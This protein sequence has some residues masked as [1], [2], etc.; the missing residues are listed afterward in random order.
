MKSNIYTF[1]ITSVLC[2]L[3][4]LVIE[5]SSPFSMSDSLF[6]YESSFMEPLFFMLLGISI[7]S[8]ILIFYKK[9]NFFVWTRKILVWFLPISLVMVAAGS[10]GAQFGTV[11][12]TVTAQVMGTLLVIIT[13]ILIT[14]QVFI[15]KKK[16][17]ETK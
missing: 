12:R 1:T 17:K 10:D 16:N 4:F 7:S 9:I 13:A 3:I 15:E 5:P 8:L 2:I 6:I 11:S 14:F